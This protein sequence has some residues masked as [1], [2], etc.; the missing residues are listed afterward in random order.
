MNWCRLG[1]VAALC[2][3]CAACGA[4]PRPSNP[5]PIATTHAAASAPRADAG[6]GPQANST[7]EGSAHPALGWI[8]DDVDAALAQG[9]REGKLVFVDAWAPWC[10]T[11]LSMKHFVL[12]APALRSLGSSV[13]FVAVDTDREQ[14]AKFVD[15][16]AIDVWPTFFLL[17]PDSG[18]VLGYW[19]GSASIRE[20]DEFVRE[21][22]AAREARQASK[23]DPKSPLVPLLAAKNAQARSDYDE[24]AKLYGQAIA[25]APANWNRRSETL[26]G[27]ISA[28]FNAGRAERCVAVG[29]KHLDEVHGASKPTDFVR[30]LYD[31]SEHLKSAA[32][33]QRVSDATLKKLQSI[34]DSP[35]PESTPDDRADTLGILASVLVD[36]GDRKRAAEVHARRLKL[37]EDAAAKAPTPAA[38]ATYDYA[39]ANAYLS[40]GRA[41]EAI[42]M[43]EAREKQLPSSYEP[44]ARLAS[45]LNALKRH[46]EALAAIDRALEHAYGPRRLGYLDLKADIQIAL[47]DRAGAV[48]TL[49]ELVAGH[50]AHA[51]RQKEKPKRWVTAKRRLEE[52]KKALSAAKQP[53]Q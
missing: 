24:A 1:L 4:A 30:T 42:Q 14:N 27:W 11:C 31:C 38:A 12:D 49:E 51:R 21:T 32:D 2:A 19:P 9:K 5:A 48:K 3:A 41:Q 35:H 36:R 13:V 18:D 15:K 16:Y 20:M 28:L 52:A 22:L 26:L 29:L 47:G 53:A 46:T 17:D 50:E 45:V 8:E 37:L 34:A 23:L 44:P 6:V 43:L 7:P 40:V 10:H 33:K 25:K 39:R